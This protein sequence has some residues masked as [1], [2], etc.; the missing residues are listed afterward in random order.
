VADFSG[1][2]Q[3]RKDV[4]PMNAVCRRR[5][6][7]GCGSGRDGKDVL[8]LDGA[9]S[10]IFDENRSVLDLSTL[11]HHHRTH[12]VGRSPLLQRQL[13]RARDHFERAAGL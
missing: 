6:F 3:A 5:R 8:L 2:K 12:E 13:R 10:R 4:N 9:P 11:Y 7:Q 1:Y